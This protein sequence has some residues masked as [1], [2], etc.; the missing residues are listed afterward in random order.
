MKEIRF[1]T[2]LGR[3]EAISARIVGVMEAANFLIQAYA[4]QNQNTGAV[5]RILDELRQIHSELKEFYNECHSQMPP[6]A[7]QALQAYCQE[8]P[9]PPS[10][11]G[12]AVE[13]QPLA[14]LQ[15]FRARFNYLIADSEIEGRNATEL[16]FE[17]LQ[18]LISVDDHMRSNWKTAFAGEERF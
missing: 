6:F 16:A 12:D 15:I 3:W 17:H 9:P 14:T 1:V 2:W 18:R 5:R 10:T 13:L 8:P 11:S 7:A 4:V